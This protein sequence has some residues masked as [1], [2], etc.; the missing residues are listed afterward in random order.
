MRTVC[1]YVYPARADQQAVGIDDARRSSN[2]EIWAYGHDQLSVHGNVADE[3]R[4]AGAVDNGA[5][6]DEEGGGDRS[7]VT[8]GRAGFRESA[9]LPRVGA[10]VSSVDRVDIYIAEYTD[11]KGAVGAH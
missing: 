6:F 3:G 4:C 7:H 10:S 8:V 5:V 9:T 11:I 2:F 1:V